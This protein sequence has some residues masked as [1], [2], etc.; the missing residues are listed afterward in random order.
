M[1]RPHSRESDISPNRY[2][3]KVNRATG[4]EI[5]G[6]IDPDDLLVHAHR[7]QNPIEVAAQVIAS[8]F[9][10]TTGRERAVER[11]LKAINEMAGRGAE[12]ASLFIGGRAFEKRAKDFLGVVSRDYSFRFR[13]PKHLSPAQIER[14]LSKARKDAA[15]KLAARGADPR[16]HILLTGATGFLGKEILF[17]AAT[18]PR[19]ARVTAIVR[20]EKITDRKT[21]DVLRVIDAPERGALLLR[22]LAL[23]AAA[24]SKFD[25]VQGDIEEP[26]FGLST[27]DHD[28]LAKS[29]THVIHC[30]ASVSFDEPY[31]TS[32]RSNVLGSINALGFS[33][34]LQ[35]RRGSPFVEHVAIETSY[36]HGRKR[37]AMAQEEALVFPR[38]FYN[39]FYEL[40]KAMASMETDRHLI[41]KGLRVAQLLP[42]IVI[43]HS[44]TGNNRGDT[45]VVNAPV[46]AFG[47]AKEISDKLKSDIAG[48][49]RRMLLQWAGG[50]FPGDPT[51]ELN[52][53]PVDRV[54]QGIIASLTVPEAIGTRIHLATDNRIRSDNVVRTVQEEL[55]VNVRLSDP[56]IYRNVTLPIVKSVLTRLGEHKLANALEKLGAIFGGYAEWGQ[57]VHSVGNDVRLLGLPIR[58]PDTENAFRMLCRHN[59]FVQEYGRVRDADEVARR[60]WAW[61]QALRR[62]EA[63]TGHQAGALR[64][65]AF[66]EHL[67]EELDLESFTLRPEHGDAKPAPKPRRSNPRRK[68]ASPR[69][70]VRKTG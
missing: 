53:V 6:P 59:R 54:V 22:R 30:A 7:D 70:A 26:S 64:P 20:S 14:R 42:S 33:L 27:R 4:R 13:E 44:E 17:Q 8:G 58:R 28:A 10:R 38:H 63:R 50:Q 24:H 51:A 35:S 49:P 32:F 55:G 25:F 41:E 47:R 39:N 46:N 45:K 23:S 34:S 31:E 65:R 12:F 21:G 5:P 2:I 29:V 37:N 19:I 18:D 66:R 40:T 36:I 3:E 68:A 43:G 56:T 60:E 11:G 15:K 48:K 61:E 69:P 52:F 62:I 67:A 16:L 1:A 57:P 9:I